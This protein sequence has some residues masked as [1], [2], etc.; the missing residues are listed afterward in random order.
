MMIIRSKSLLL[1]LAVLALSAC[2][3]SG[4]PEKTVEDYITAVAAGDD[5]RAANLACTEWEGQARIDADSFMNVETTI[6]N[7]A[8]EVIARTESRVDV[9]CSGYITA[10]YQGKNKKIDLSLQTYR[11]IS[12][13]GVWRVCGNP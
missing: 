8:C 13:N 5:I 2:G 7:M 6:E 1:I 11:L 3:V 12:E 10:D 4:M 9:Q